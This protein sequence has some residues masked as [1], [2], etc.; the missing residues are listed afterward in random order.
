[1]LNEQGL[2]ESRRLGAGSRKRY[3]QFFLRS[4]STTED[5]Q[6]R[7]TVWVD[8]AERCSSSAKRFTIAFTTDREEKVEVLAG[9]CDPRNNLC[10]HKTYPSIHQTQGQEWMDDYMSKVT[11]PARKRL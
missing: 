11:A 5:A 8:G 10:W 7:I 2:G 3:E 9:K 6:R 1:M 4:G